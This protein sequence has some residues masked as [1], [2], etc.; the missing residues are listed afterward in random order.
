MRTILISGNRRGL[1][2]ALTDH[3]RS[4][5]HTVLGFSPSS[6]E[7]DNVDVS[8]YVQVDQ[9]INEVLAGRVPDLVVAN[10]GVV[11]PPR[12]LWEVEPA[13]LSTLI[14]VNVKGVFNLFRC[15]LPAMLARR[16]GVLVAI[17]SGYGRS[18]TPRMSG[19]CSSKWAVEG[20]VKSLSQ[21]L[22]KGMA[23]V[24]LDPGTLQTDMLR[25][26]LGKGASFF[27]TPDQWVERASQLLLA[28]G[29]EHNGQSLSV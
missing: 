16:S 11:L 20:L 13:E 1:G 9:W 29:S 7:P 10:A 15:V 2:K 28:L 12:P 22:P 6:P 27:P 18:T 25:T 3:W 4:L 23:A 8:E 5:G 14:D 21:E 17:S 19:Y 26:A 24:A